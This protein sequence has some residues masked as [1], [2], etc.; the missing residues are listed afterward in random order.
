MT[1]TI[2]CI[3]ESKEFFMTGIDVAVPLASVQSILSYNK[4]FFY[5]GETPFDFTFDWPRPVKAEIICVIS[6]SESYIFPAIITGSKIE[7]EVLVLDLHFA[8]YV[9]NS[10]R[11]RLPQQEQLGLPKKLY[12]EPKLSIV[13]QD[14]FSIY[15]VSSSEEKEYFPA[16][17]PRVEQMEE[18]AKPSKPW[19]RKIFGG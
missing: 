10:H 14:H 18:V 9:L 1:I 12:G 8:R 4:K 6:E 13:L 5:N 3:N 7:K 17:L 19:Y 11:N 16:S 15:T 2:P